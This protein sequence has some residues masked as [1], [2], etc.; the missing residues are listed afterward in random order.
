VQSWNLR[1]QRVVERAGF[2][3]SRTF[4]VDPGS[5]G[6]SVTYTELRRAW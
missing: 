5:G 6:E 2:T 1:G 3:A 4:V